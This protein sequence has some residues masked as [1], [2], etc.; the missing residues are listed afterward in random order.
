MKK[1]VITGLGVLASNGQGK[2]NF[3]R[4]LQAGVAGYGPLTV[5]DP[6]PFRVKQAAEIKDFDAKVYLG[7]KGFRTL[8]RSSRLAVSATKCAIEDSG[9]QID[10][11]N[12]PDVGVA[13]GTTFGSL[14]SIVDFDTV[15]LKEGPRYTNPGLFPNTVIN[16]PGSQISIWHNIQGFNTTI[17]TGFTA[18]L[19]AM[20]YAYDF[21]QLDRV[22]VVYTGGL[23]ELCWP[24]FMGLHSLQFLSGSR[25]GQTFVN[26]PFD[27][28]RNGIT[29]GEGACVM[30]MEDYDHAVKRGARIMAEVLSF[31]H[32]FDPYRINK[33]NPRGTGMVKAMRAALDGAGL[34][35]GDIDYICANANST[36]A[37]DKIECQ[38]IQDVFGARAKMIPV[39]AV[40]SMV[41][42]CYSVSGA[43]AVAASLGAL[44]KDFIPP[45]INYANPDPDCP[46][47]VVPNTARSA[48]VNRI[49][50]NNFSPTGNQACM[51][52]ARAGSAA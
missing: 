27:L 2:D 37:A 31:G 11:T 50:I 8:D 29:L 34:E 3:W 42:E 19:D 16:A 52:I 21:L 28:R 49:L 12:S 6:E 38:A 35:A 48:R 36:L 24:L 4:A 25:E 33:Y 45:T 32:Y 1:I 30:A 23:E 22:K 41:G 26:C 14:Q 46:L 40:K 15:I 39:S 43:L 18:S 17:A 5:F 20:K 51:V 44:E 10:D 47:D 7:P 13:L 9:F